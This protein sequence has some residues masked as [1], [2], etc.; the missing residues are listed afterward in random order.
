MINKMILCLIVLLCFEICV[1]WG[2][3]LPSS[4]GIRKLQIE[5]LTS[6]R[7]ATKAYFSS[8]YRKAAEL[9]QKAALSGV[10]IV[11]ILTSQAPQEGNNQGET[12]RNARLNACNFFINAASSYKKAGDFDKADSMLSTALEYAERWKQD[13]IMMKS[14]DESASLKMERRQFT[15]ASH[16]YVKLLVIV[17]EELS[18]DRWIVAMKKGILPETLAGESQG[19]VTKRFQK[20][21]SEWYIYSGA[22]SCFEY[23]QDLDRSLQILNMPGFSS[24]NELFMILER[25]VTETSGGGKEIPKE[26]QTFFQSQNLDNMIFLYHMERSDLL[27]KSGHPAEA[28]K[29][30]DALFTALH[31]PTSVFKEMLVPLYNLKGLIYDSMGKYREALEAYHNGMET[32]ERMSPPG[33]R[34]YESVF[35]INMSHSLDREGQLKEASEY[36]EKAA[37][38]ARS[39]KDDDILWHALF[40]EAEASYDMGDYTKS[41]MLLEEAIGIVE[42]IRSNITSEE[43]RRLFTSDKTGIYDLMIRALKKLHRDR[44]ALQYAERLKARSFVEL[45]GNMDMTKIVKRDIP[46][47]AKEEFKEVMAQLDKLK[48]MKTLLEKDLLQ[49][50]RDDAALQKISEKSENLS[51]HYDEMEKRFLSSLRPL[52]EEFRD[53]CTVSAADFREISAMLDSDT[54]LLEYFVGKGESSVLLFLVSYE[55]G[56]SE[57][58]VSCIELPLTGRELMDEVISLRNLM[59]ESASSASQIE[60][61]A[62]ALYGK[63]ITPCER[64][65]EGKKR[66]LLVPSGA[67]YFLPFAVLHRTGGHYLIDSH[68]L[69]YLPSATTL[70]YCKKKN[71]HRRESMMIYALGNGSYTGMSNLPGTLKEEEGI[72]S[73]VTGWKVDCYRGKDLTSSGFRD[74]VVGKDIIHLA[75]HGT[76]NLSYPPDSYVVIGSDLLRLED[77]MMLDLHAD[78]VTLSACQTAL[79]KYYRGDEIVGLTRAFIYAGTPSV[80]SSLWSVSDESTVLLMASYYR[81]LRDGADKAEALRMAQCEIREKYP[82]PFHWAPFILSGDWQ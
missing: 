63:I 62:D 33:R 12:V 31:Q 66:L 67:L 70:R 80:I 82:E 34:I 14:L 44:D 61:I 48:Q 41:C 46:A 4:E 79:G 64:F 51:L 20:Y 74:A 1:S 72:K 60:R 10:K 7:E 75:T 6:Y 26:I 35:L 50:P 23:L 57:P 5:E 32:A 8:D 76:L 2:R 38:G 16:L 36:A 27:R 71:I 9:Y 65:I 11:E 58:S 39:I 40:A 53:M 29:E 17:E 68:D 73:A 43:Q 42:S 30:V 55:K 3:E 81:H 37:A 49:G 24:L 59:L 77:I 13:S 21:I 56:A 28:M 22:A 45:L 25:P 19:E 52:G 47:K 18:S 15:E 69:V 78:L 54:V